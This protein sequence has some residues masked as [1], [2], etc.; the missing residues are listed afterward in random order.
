MYEHNVFPPL[1]HPSIKPGP[2]KYAVL[3]GGTIT[4][5]CGSNPA[6]NPTPSVHWIDNR[7]SLHPDHSSRISLSIDRLRLTITRVR[8]S[9][10]GDWLCVLTG[11]NTNVNISLT[12]N[13]LISVT[14]VGEF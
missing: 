4:L 9:D 10:D 6:G 3:R 1:D 14:V 7:G 5:V 2:G 11:E 12:H 8:P 13:E